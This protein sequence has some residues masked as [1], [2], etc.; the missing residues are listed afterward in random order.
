MDKARTVKL[1]PPGDGFG[2]NPDY[3]LSELSDMEYGTAA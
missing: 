1:P 3:G 2:K